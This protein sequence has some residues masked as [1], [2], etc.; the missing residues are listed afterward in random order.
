M[1]DL[2]DFTIGPLKLLT[3]SVKNNN[4]IL[5]DIEGNKRLIA[6]VIGFDSH[7]NMVLTNVKEVWSETR[8]GVI[9]KK[10][11]H[12][13]KMFLPGHNVKIIVKNPKIRTQ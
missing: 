9:E 12:I 10:E 3:E 7:F 2:S 5:I 4:R 1:E 11:R 13:A 6:H 8:R